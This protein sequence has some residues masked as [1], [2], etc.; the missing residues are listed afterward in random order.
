[1]L[2]YTK[3]DGESMPNLSDNDNGWL[4]NASAVRLEPTLRATLGNQKQIVDY[5]LEVG[6]WDQDPTEVDRTLL[7]EM[8][9]SLPEF[10][11]TPNAADTSLGGSDVMNPM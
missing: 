9:N 5:I 2:I 6:T 11:Q 7:A 10:Y 8:R 1:M 4:R 3:G